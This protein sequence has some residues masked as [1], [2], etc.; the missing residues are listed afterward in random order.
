M[1]VLDLR[2]EKGEDFICPDDPIDVP[3]AAALMGGALLAIA[4]GAVLQEAA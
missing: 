1:Q 2:L 4:E 3:V